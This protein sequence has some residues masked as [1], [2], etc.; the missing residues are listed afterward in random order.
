MHLKTPLLNIAY[1]KNAE[2]ERVKYTYKKLD[3]YRMAV[4]RKLL[5]NWLKIGLESI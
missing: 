5:K 2:I 4:W 3:W 1:S